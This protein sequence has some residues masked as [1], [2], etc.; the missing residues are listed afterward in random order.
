[1]AV[2]DNAHEELAGHAGPAAAR[3]HWAVPDPVPAV[4]VSAVPVSVS[5]PTDADVD[6]AFDAA[7]RDLAARVERLATTLQAT[8]G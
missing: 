4:P 5:V 7:Y 2:C 3:L 1:V 8:S 6:A